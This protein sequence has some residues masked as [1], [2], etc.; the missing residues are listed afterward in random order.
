M[1][2]HDYAD[3]KSMEIRDRNGSYILMKDG[4]IEIHAAG[5]IKLTAGRIDLN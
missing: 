3:D 2:F 5:N 1:H 4:N